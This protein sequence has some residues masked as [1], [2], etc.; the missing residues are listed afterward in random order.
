M[1]F[2]FNNLDIIKLMIIR[3]IGIIDVSRRI[4]NISSIL[5]SNTTLN[6]NQFKAIAANKIFGIS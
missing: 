5:K 2:L 3:K 4:I 6:N 1:T